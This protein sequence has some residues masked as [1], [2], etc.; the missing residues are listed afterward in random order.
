MNIFCKNKTEF[1]L[2]EAK[3]QLNEWKYTNFGLWGAEFPYYFV[4][5]KILAAPY[6]GDIYDYKTFCFNGNPKFIAVRKILNKERNRFIYNYYDL[7]WTLTDIE[8]GS[9]IYKRDP[10]VNF[11]KP[12]NLDLLIEYSKKLSNEFVF[13]RVDFY[14]IDGT[15]Y[16]GELTFVPSNLQN[17]FKDIAQRKY[18]G[19]LLDVTKIK[20]YLFNK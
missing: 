19:S 7:N 5:R 16:L 2:E 3:K 6:M 1:N 17:S 11:E 8:Y 15:I 14:I 13:V 9:S 4:D 10:K 12:K 20:P 18:L